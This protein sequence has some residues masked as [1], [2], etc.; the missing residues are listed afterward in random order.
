MGACS[1]D[2][3]GDEDW[4]GALEVLARHVAGDGLEAAE[5][6]HRLART[7][8]GL[9]ALTAAEALHRRAGLLLTGQP[10]GGRIDRRRVGWACALAA[11]LV[12]QNRRKE[13]EGVLLAAV[14]LAEA[15]L[16]PDDE[17]THFARACL[18][19]VLDGGT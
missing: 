12:A 4:A 18:R 14:G 5:V 10:T 13:A 9:G 3:E 2:G 8:E 7:L 19:D 17:E 16:G 1:T 6:S 15:L 11:N